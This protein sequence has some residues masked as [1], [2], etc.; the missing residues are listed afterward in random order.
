M[1]L[2]GMVSHRATTLFALLIAVQGAHSIEE[3]AFR[4][5][6]VFAP[7]RFVSGVV[8]DNRAIGFA[9]LN[10]AIMTLGV[11]CFVARVRPG[12]RSAAAWVWFWVL[13]EAGNGTG[14]LLFATITGGYVPGAST[15]PFLLVTAVWLGATLARRR[16]DA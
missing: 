9:L 10:V 3:Y 16:R 7:A 1:S 13:L 12:H 15:A 2:A 4:L 6:D 8:S 11:W 14:H 5:Y